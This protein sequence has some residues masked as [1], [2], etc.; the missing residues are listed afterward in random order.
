MK[1]QNQN[2]KGGGFMYK[3]FISF[4]LLYS[5]LSIARLTHI[6]M[7]GGSFSKFIVIAILA[8]LVDICGFFY[9]RKEHVG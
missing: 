1:Q 2:R 8:V 3:W 6:M 9:S 7:S 5:M 4:S